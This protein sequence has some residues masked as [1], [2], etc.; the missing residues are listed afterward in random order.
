MVEAVGSSALV[1]SLVR[2]HQDDLAET[3]T[4]EEDEL[5]SLLQWADDQN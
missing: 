4:T 3:D 2:R 1:V 5:L